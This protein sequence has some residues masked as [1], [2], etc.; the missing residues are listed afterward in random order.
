MH[1]YRHTPSTIQQDSAILL[2]HG[3]FHGAWMWEGN[4]LNYYLEQGFET[5]TIDLSGRGKANRKFML[6]LNDLVNDLKQAIRQIDKEIILVGHSMGCL[7]AQKYLEQHQTK[8]AV[9]LCPL[10][11]FGM[12]KSIGR[13]A[14]RKPSNFFKFGMMS[15]FNVKSTGKNSKP[16]QGI[17]AEDISRELMKEHVSKMNG[18]SKRLLMQIMFQ[19]VKIDAVKNTPIK[20]IGSEDDGL[21]LKEDVIEMA[22]R[23]ELP[24]TLY[25]DMGH[26]MFIAPNWRDVAHETFEW[27][28]KIT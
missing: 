23:Y 19:N 28:Q 9:L 18:E 27:I 13:V 4:F 6:G 21:I 22:R 10:P 1:L 26:A 24:Y 5:Y 11:P 2:I 3:A 8:G 14:V 15:I 17:F 20:I 25:P 7:I 12:H 16:P